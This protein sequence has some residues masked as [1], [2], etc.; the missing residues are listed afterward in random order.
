MRVTNHELQGPRTRNIN[1]PKVDRGLAVLIFDGWIRTSGHKQLDGIHVTPE[2]SQMQRC[3]PALQQRKMYE[4]N[5]AIIHR[6][7]EGLSK[8]IVQCIN[9]W[10]GFEKRG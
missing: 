4:W 5:K 2:C 9:F 1:A 8:D 10:V 3:G 7:L 6:S